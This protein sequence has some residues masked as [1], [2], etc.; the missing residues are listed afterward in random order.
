M[1][2]NNLLDTPKLNNGL[3]QIIKIV[4]SIWL[5]RV[6]EDSKRGKNSCDKIHVV[7]SLHLD[8]MALKANVAHGVTVYTYS[9]YPS[10]REC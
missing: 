2:K 7:S 6:K 10:F 1:K 5:K 9:A 3:F 4:D 8:Y